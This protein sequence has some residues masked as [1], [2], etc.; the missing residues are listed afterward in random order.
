MTFFAELPIWFLAIL[1]FLLRIVDVSMGTIRTVAIIE[2]KSVAATILGFFEVL[3]WVVVVA[4]V[5]VRIDESLWLAIAFAG[6]FAAGNAVGI[7]A[8]RKLAY[9]TAVLRMISD[10]KGAEIA[11]VLQRLG[12][13]VTTFLGE[14]EGGQVTLVYAAAPRRN[15]AKLLE[16]AIAVDPSMFFVVE[17]ANTLVMRS[18]VISRPTGWRAFLKM[19]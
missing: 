3:V 6:G 14:G 15:I 18:G 13:K 9:G 4:Q 16:T 11:A 10:E 1:I 12:Q 2:G 19:K 8:E 5:I 17:R 7:A